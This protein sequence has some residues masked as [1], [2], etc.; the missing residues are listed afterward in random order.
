MKGSHVSRS[1]KL[2]WNALASTV[3]CIA[4][5]IDGVLNTHVSIHHID[6]RTKPGAHREVLPL[7]APHHQQDDSDPLQRIAVHPNKAQFE[8]RYG[9]Q[10]ELLA[11]CLSILSERSGAC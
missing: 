10:R 9:N 5:R 2:F 7:C 11:R 6:G 3:G 4:C 8:R 1:T